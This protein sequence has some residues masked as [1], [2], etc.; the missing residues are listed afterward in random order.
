MFWFGAVH[1]EQDKFSGFA[2]QASLTTGVGY[3]F[4]DNESTKLI[5]HRW[6]RLPAPAA[7]RS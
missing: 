5:G 6:R 2:Y 4:I 3:K 1:G 7:G